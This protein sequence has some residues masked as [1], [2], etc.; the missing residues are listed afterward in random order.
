MSISVL[1]LTITIVI[2]LVWAKY[3]LCGYLDL[4]GSRC[5]PHSWRNGGS[6]QPLVQS[7]SLMSS[8]LGFNIF[9]MI[10]RLG[11]LLVYGRRGLKVSNR[12]LGHERSMGHFRAS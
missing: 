7:Q 8:A 6:D 12:K 2:M 1:L 5:P 10:Y 9:N 3:S 11:A 4:L